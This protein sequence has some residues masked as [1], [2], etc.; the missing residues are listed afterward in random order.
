MQCT[1][2]RLWNIKKYCRAN[3]GHVQEVRREIVPEAE[4]AGGSLEAGGVL[5]KLSRRMAP[6]L[7]L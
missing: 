5:A 4:L 7:V 2:I 3:G 6:G 1:E